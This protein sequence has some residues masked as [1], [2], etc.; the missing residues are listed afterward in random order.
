MELG[1]MPVLMVS[2]Y[3]LKMDPHWESLRLRVGILIA[4]SS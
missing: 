3:G 1:I 4:V 2:L